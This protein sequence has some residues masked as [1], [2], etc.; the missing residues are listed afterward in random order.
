M[1]TKHQTI[2]LDNNVMS[3]LSA[4][5]MSEQQSIEAYANKLL[6]LV[7]NIDSQEPEVEKSAAEK[8]LA[9]IEK[10]CGV[11]HDDGVDYKQIT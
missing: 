3:A 5:A 4:R 7:L 1:I 6:R 11:L 2:R 8:R 9:C 10:L